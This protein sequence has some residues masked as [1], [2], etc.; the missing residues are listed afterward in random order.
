VLNKQLADLLLANSE[1]RHH[2]TN[3]STPMAQ[4]DCP[5]HTPLSHIL[6]IEVTASSEQFLLKRVGGEG[7][8]GHMCSVTYIIL[9]SPDS[10]MS[11][12]DYF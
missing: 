3:M 1:P 10:Q 2:T 5:A 9:Q 7:V 6:L 11:F 8:H 4:G 12:L